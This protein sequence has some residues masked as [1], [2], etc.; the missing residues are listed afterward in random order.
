MTKYWQLHKKINLERA[1]LIYRTMVEYQHAED[2]SMT[3]REMAEKLGL[4]SNS[5]VARYLKYLEENGYA[6]SKGRQIRAIPQE[7]KNG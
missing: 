1:M 3:T 5:D 2:F 7:E 6:K 4:K